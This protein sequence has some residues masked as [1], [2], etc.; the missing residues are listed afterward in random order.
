MTEAERPLVRF[1]DDNDHVEHLQQLLI[2]HGATI[3]ADG[4]FGPKTLAAVRTF[5]EA[6]GLLVDGKVGS[7]TWGVLEAEQG[8]VVA[9]SI[10]WSGAVDDASERDEEPPKPDFKPIVGNHGRQAV[11]GKFKYAPAPTAGNLEGIRFKDDWPD[12]NIV[13]IEIP[14]LKLIQ[15]VEHQG[16]IIGAGPKSGKVSV[17]R[18]VAKQIQGLWRMWGEEGLIE[19]TILTWAGL[20]N[21][22]FIR[23]TKKMHEAGIK[24]TVLSNHSF[25][26]AFDIN[27]PWNGFGREPARRGERG[28]VWDLVPIAHE[29]G[30]YWG[31][32]FK[33]KDGMHFEVAKVL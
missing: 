32:H 16:R 24:P 31:G 12:R 4:D 28:C 23:I 21:P 5:Q 14:E 33:R 26:T 11:F 15:G 13:T 29:F 6:T 9:T 30:F 17:H 18:M 1:G 2:A 27:A 22:R 25:A 10:E 3:I 8:A 19:E 20:W 7:L